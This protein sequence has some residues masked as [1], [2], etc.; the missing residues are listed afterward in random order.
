MNKEEIIRKLKEHKKYLALIV[1]FSIIT[2]VIVIP[3]ML[4]INSQESID[5]LYQKS[6]DGILIEDR[7]LEHAEGV[8]YGGS[9]GRVLEATDWF[10]FQ[11]HAKAGDWYHAHYVADFSP[12]ILEMSTGSGGSGENWGSVKSKTLQFTQSSIYTVKVNNYDDENDGYIFFFLIVYS[13]EYYP[14]ACPLS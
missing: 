12:I 2:A 1:I 5:R 13:N 4:V 14:P 8:D 6:R 7:F 3:I 9:I 11:I 10:T